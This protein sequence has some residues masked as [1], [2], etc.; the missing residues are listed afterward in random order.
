MAMPQESPG[1]RIVAAKPA[2][3]GAEP[4]VAVIIRD[5]RGDG[6]VRQRILPRILQNDTL[7]TLSIG[8]EPAKSA[9]RSHPQVSARIL[10]DR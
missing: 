6:L 2:A 5:Q 1:N 3:I 8:T 7:K 4:H 9:I 10:R